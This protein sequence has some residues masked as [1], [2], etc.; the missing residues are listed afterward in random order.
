MLGSNVPAIGG[1]SIALDN[2]KRANCECIQIYLANS[3]KW[4]V[5]HMDLNSRTNVLEKSKEYK[6]SMVAH[7]PFLVNIASSNEDLWARSVERLKFEIEAAKLLNV[8]KLVIH[9][10]SYTSGDKL[11]G[12]KKIIKAINNI[13]DKLEINNVFLLLETMSGRGTEIG[14]DFY[15]LREI[16]NGVKNNSHIGVCFDTCHVYSAGYDITDVASLKNTLIEFDRIVGNKRIMTFHLNN[17]LSRVGSKKDR[18]RKICS[19]NIS[20]ETFA[21]IVNN[22]AF[23]NIPKIIEPASSESD[24]ILQ[25][26][27]LINLKRE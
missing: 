24:Y 6:I 13:S 9:P 11:N 23:K 18:H 2:A 8:T 27:H 7:I 4:N 12:I 26:N 17:T 15:E 10:G 14:G 16:I 19:G 22:H 21:F 5:L 1:L 3:R 25:M 20:E